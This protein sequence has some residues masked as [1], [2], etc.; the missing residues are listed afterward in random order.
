MRK[1]ILLIM[2]FF[3]YSCKNKSN[4]EIKFEKA[5]LSNGVEIETIA[6]NDKQYKDILNKNKNL[7]RIYNSITANDSEIIIYEM[8]NNDI[9]VS[10][11][12]YH[13][14]YKSLEDL[15]RVINDFDEGGIEILSTT[16]KF[17]QDFPCHTEELIK[18]L[19]TSLGYKPVEQIN[20]DLTI[21]DKKIRMNNDIRDF[22]E[23]HILNYIA[24]IGKIINNEYG[25]KWEMCVAKDNKTWNPF[26]IIDNNKID[27]VSYT[28]EDL[29]ENNNGL[30][31]L[32][33][34]IIDIIN[35]R[36][37]TP[38]ASRNNSNG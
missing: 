33:E 38:G 24:L 11:D 13:S 19:C 34:S 16:N 4:M 22:N 31:H 5:Q 30:V 12:G 9:L 32:K 17:N 15:V 27:I 3:I 23:K 21:L 14:I 35:S 29:V 28:Y 25:G 36:R 6:L 7:K 8:E 10:S 18:N 26:L 1:Y 37:N 2:L 20:Y